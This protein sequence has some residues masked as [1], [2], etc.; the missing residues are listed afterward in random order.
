MAA[1]AAGLQV[2]LSACAGVTLH[3]RRIV[4]KRML[5]IERCWGPT[6]AAEPCSLHATCNDGATALQRAAQW[7]MLPTL[8]NEMGG[9]GCREDGVADVWGLVQLIYESEESVV[10]AVAG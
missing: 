10:V 8:I 3:W 5:S 9:G 7:G 4:Q 1:T 2:C 6:C